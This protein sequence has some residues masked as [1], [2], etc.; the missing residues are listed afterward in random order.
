MGYSRPSY[1]HHCDKGHRLHGATKSWPPNR[2]LASPRNETLVEHS[3]SFQHA[4]ASIAVN[5]L[6]E[7]I[8]ERTSSWCTQVHTARGIKTYQDG[9]ASG[10][11]LE[12]VNANVEDT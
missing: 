7:C 5:V 9:T 10:R 12:P 8:A 6:L 4:V 2:K 1:L 3:H 11:S